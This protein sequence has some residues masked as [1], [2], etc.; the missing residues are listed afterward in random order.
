[1]VGR[2]KQQARTPKSRV[3]E[4]LCVGQGLF[5]WGA[6][7]ALTGVFGCGGRDGVTTEPDAGA[8][9]VHVQDGGQ[10]TFDSQ[11]FPNYGQTHVP[12]CSKVSYETIPPSSGDHYPIWA[13][14]KEYSKPVPAGFLVHAMEHGAAVVFYNC[15]QGCSEELDQIR[16]MISQLPADPKCMGFSAER[17]VILTPSEDL[18]VPFAVGAWRNTLRATCFDASIFSGFISEHYG[19]GPEDFC[20]D[21]QDVVGDGTSLPS[22]C[23]K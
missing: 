12:S 23:G 19:K 18:D 3:G 8:H 20:S 21:G 5:L 1:V 15:P 16:T 22:D 10:C 11:A 17:R 7:L 4:R 2:R 14:F 13:A 9:I 6:C